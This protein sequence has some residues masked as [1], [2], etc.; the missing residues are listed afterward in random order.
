MFSFFKKRIDKNL[1]LFSN[2]HTD[3]HSHLIPGVDDGSPDIESSIFYIKELVKLGFK[4]II[5]TPHVMSD[6]YPNTSEKL[7]EGYYLLKKH[8]EEQSVEVEFG[9]GAEYFLDENFDNILSQ[10]QI[11]SFGN[12]HVLIEMS[13]I[14]PYRELH[15]VVFNLISKGYTP[16][17]AHP[18][19]YP[20]FANKLKKLNEIKDMGCL[21]Q[22]NTLSLTNYYGTT[23]QKLALQLFANNM[24][25]FISTD[26]H[27]KRHLEAL[28]NFPVD[29][30]KLIEKSNLLNNTL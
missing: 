30:Q 3:F 24:V 23:V 13:F 17:L 7:L 9:L 15:Q 26:L 27:H 10:N 4:K 25:E 19:R 28:Q 20:Y 12:N 14:E 6:F 8:L 18:E 22:V 29:K 2:I 1:P 21:F 5:T 11:L 16:I